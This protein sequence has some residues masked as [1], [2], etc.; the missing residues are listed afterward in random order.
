[1]SSTPTARRVS[2]EDA[3]NVRPSDLPA[4][5]REALRVVQACADPH[6]TSQHLADLVNK[7]PAMTAE[8]L[9]IANSALFG[10]SCTSSGRSPS[11]R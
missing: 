4:P 2:A 3:A 5:P 6:V 1:M 7:D 10:V 9:R 8:I 11:N